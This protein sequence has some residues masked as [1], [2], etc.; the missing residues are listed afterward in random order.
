VAGIGDFQPFPFQCLPAEA[1]DAALYSWRISILT[2]IGS[3]FFKKPDKRFFI[4]SF[5]SH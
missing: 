5:G 3:L 2:A 1:G 4:M